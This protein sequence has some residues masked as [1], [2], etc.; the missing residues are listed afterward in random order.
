VKLSVRA[1]VDALK[2]F[3]R[4][5][6]ERPR[7]A[8]VVSIA[9]SLSGLVALWKLPVAQ[10][11]QVT[12]PRVVVSCSYPGA[13]AA[14]VMNTIAGPLEDEMNGVEDM[15]FMSSSCADDGSYSLGI[16]FEVGTDRD[17]ALMKVQNRVQQAM[18]KLPVEVKNTG[19]R[20][21]CASEDQLGILTLRSRS[22]GLSRI[23]VSDYMFGVV[24]PALLRVPGVGEASI[25]GPK[26]AMRVWLD[27]KRCAALGINSEE[28]VAAIKAQNVQ[29]SLG[30]VGSSPTDDKYSRILTLMAKGRLK[31]PEEF[32]EIVVR[33]DGNGGIVRL[34]DLARAELGEQGYT[35]NNSFNNKTSISVELNQLPGGNAIRTMELVRKTMAELEKRFPGDLEWF[36]PYDTTDYVRECL[37]EIVIT[38]GLTVLLVALVCWLFLQDWRATLVPV[39]TIPVSLLSTFTVMAVLGYSVNIMTLFGLVLA[40]GTVV[41]DAIVVVERVQ[42][43]MSRGLNAKEAAIQAMHDVTS[44]VVATTLVLLGIFVPVGFLGGLTGKIYQQFSVTLSTAVVFSTVNALTLSPALCATLMK[45]SSS[46]AGRRKSG[47]FRAFDAALASSSRLYV[48]A[49]GV[50]ARRRVLLALVLAVV[51]CGAISLAKSIPP[52]FIPHEDQGTIMVDANMPE[53]TARSLATEAA[54]ESVER[55]LGVDG[56][57]SVLLTVGHSR[58]GGRGENQIQMTVNLKPWS[59]RRSPDLEVRAVRARINETNSTLPSL[60]TRAFAPPPIPGFGSIGGIEP[61]IFSLGD[62][63]PMRLARVAKSIAADLTASPL[64]AS[65]VFGYNA[66]T[67]HLHLEVDRVKCE[68]FH[69]PLSTLYATLQNYL[70]SLY[71]ND[72]NLGTQVNRVTVQADYSGRSGAEAVRKLFVRSTTG[73]MV[74]VGSLVSFR[75]SLGPRA[76]YR[77]NQYVYCSILCTPARNVQAGACIRE[78]QRIL[79]EKLPPDYGYDW[80]GLTFHEMRARGTAAPLLALAIL[81]GYL[82]LVAQYE[83]WTIPVPVMLSVSAAVLGALGGLK[84][85]ELDLSIYAQLGIVLLIGL[86]SKNAI[87]VVEFAKDRHER[88]GLGVVDAALAGA[89]ERFRAVLMT[90]LTFVLGIAPLVWATGAGAGSRRA[91][92]TATFAGMIAATFFGIALVPGLY[93]IFQ[94]LREVIKPSSRPPERGQTPPLPLAP[95]LSDPAARDAA[96]ARLDSATALLRSDGDALGLAAREIL[97]T[98]ANVAN[99]TNV[100]NCQ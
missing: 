49:A 6:I 99:V 40:I 21:R 19:L 85:A 98:V 59:E 93:V 32:G 53:G 90:A 14:E 9:L 13:N 65:A 64:I 69:V 35:H 52:A 56:V 81:F 36:I 46:S 73:A 58:I 74:P 66:D 34:K 68:A 100:A 45:G 51:V 86:A 23:E 41:D 4:F 22:G 88:D 82:F 7:F 15:L 24:Q 17:V 54:S 25:H 96:V 77:R 38:L 62:A 3:S 89:R 48:F 47:L 43:L 8:A 71:V 29:A 72:V 30:S 31:T 55:M 10:Y 28:V 20:M 87:L 95:W 39:V 2:P 84:L 57:N 70:G 79:D 83:S 50:F 5:F 94:S 63:D 1:A 60:V 92:G 18:S 61:A 78:V 16:T 12:P 75:E 91:I 80:T 37:R 76:I 11:P 97:Q 42:E 26:M 27:P 33:R 44:A 67:P